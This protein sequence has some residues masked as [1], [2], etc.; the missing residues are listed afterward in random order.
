[1]PVHRSSD[2]HGCFFLKV[3]L[4]KSSTFKKYYYI[5]NNTASRANAK[6]LATKQGIAIH[7]NV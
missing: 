1:M 6:R 2:R 4:L 5:P 3:V 7:A